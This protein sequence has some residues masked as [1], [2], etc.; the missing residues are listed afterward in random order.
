LSSA[1][2]AKTQLRYGSIMVGISSHTPT[3]RYPDYS[4]D[5]RHV[6]TGI[7]HAVWN[8]L[9]VILIF[10]LKSVLDCCDFMTDCWGKVS[11][12]DFSSSSLTTSFFSSKANFEYD[13]KMR[14]RFLRKNRFGWCVYKDRLVPSLIAMLLVVAFVCFY[15]VD[16]F[17]FFVFELWLYLST[18]ILSNLRKIATI[19]ACCYIQR[20]LDTFLCGPIYELSWFF[21]VQVFERH[22]W[23]VVLFPLATINWG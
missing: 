18:G 19:F 2:E 21:R 5:W 22:L 14:F 8:C 15:E 4:D 13:N 1:I 12:S 23:R 11:I 17:F 6:A 10:I 3:S 9:I 20:V 16:I 7:A